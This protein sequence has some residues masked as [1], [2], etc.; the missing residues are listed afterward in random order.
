VPIVLPTVSYTAIVSHVTDAEWASTNLGVFVCI[1]CS[2]VHRSLGVHVS[3]M[4]SLT[5]DQWDETLFKSMQDLGNR[6]ANAYW[7]CNLLPFEKPLAH[8]MRY[9][10]LSNPLID[11]Y[12][13]NQVYRE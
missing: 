5:L 4:R 11:Q 10:Q 2:G 9:V 3:K 12:L 13:P 1:N 6:K 8:D 7:E